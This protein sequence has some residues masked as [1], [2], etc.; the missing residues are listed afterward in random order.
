MS[1]I[2]PLALILVVATTASAAE[3]SFVRDVQPILARKCFPCH[4]PD[5]HDRQGDLRLDF[6]EEAV[7]AGAI[8]TGPRLRLESIR[9][10]QAPSITTR[11]AKP[12]AQIARWASSPN[13]GS[14][15]NG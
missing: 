2:G 10:A 13:I 4:G 9:T 8:A 1:R 15:R 7:S 5:E 11:A 12:V 6:R 3:P 14:I